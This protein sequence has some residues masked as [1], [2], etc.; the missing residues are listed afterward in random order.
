[1]NAGAK[2]SGDNRTVQDFYDDAF[3]TESDWLRQAKVDLIRRDPVDA[4][5]DA[6]ALLQFS[7][8]RIRELFPEL[9][10]RAAKTP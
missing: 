1:M 10:D 3:D 8:D 5:N 9:K 4:F 2:M 7:A 6:E